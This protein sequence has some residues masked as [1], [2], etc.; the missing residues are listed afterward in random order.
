MLIRQSA[1]YSF[2]LRALARRI[3]S[4]AARARTES[5]L[6]FK[7]LAMFASMNFSQ[8]NSLY[9]RHQIHLDRPARRKGRLSTG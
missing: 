4:L 2:T 6:Q 5:G 7:I 8:R 3:F 1:G 9:L